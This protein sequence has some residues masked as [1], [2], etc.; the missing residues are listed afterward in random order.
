METSSPK[1]G[2]DIHAIQA[3]ALRLDLGEPEVLV[4]RANPNSDGVSWEL[5]VVELGQDEK[6]WE[7]AERVVATTIGL[8]S[9]KLKHLDKPL[10]GFDRNRQPIEFCLIAIDAD[11]NVVD[12]ALEPS[13]G[14]TWLHLGEALPG[15]AV[16]SKIS[17]PDSEGARP[18]EPRPLRAP[19]KQL[20]L[21]VVCFWNWVKRARLV[22]ELRVF[23]TSSYRTVLRGNTP[24]WVRQ[25]ME[26]AFKNA[27]DAA[28]HMRVNEGWRCLHE[29]RRLELFALTEEELAVQASI[30][31]AE[32]HKQNEFENWRKN[33]VMT[34]TDAEAVKNR[35]ADA[36][37]QALYLS[38]CI[39]DE[40]FEDDYYRLSLVSA[41]TM[42]MS[43]ALALMLGLILSQ[44]DDLAP[45]LGIT[46]LISMPMIALLGA[47]GGGFSA[48]VSFTRI[49]ADKR[50]PGRI[51]EAL[52]FVARPVIGAISAIIVIGAY[53]TGVVQITGATSETGWLILLLAF[54][55]GFSERLVMAAMERI[56]AKSSTA[57]SDKPG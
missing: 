33:A 22:G 13:Q 32:I 12:A 11:E 53:Q 19:P 5:P 56:N 1:N 30:L 34:L 44:W 40:Q 42:W 17:T 39:R 18:A 54:G 7:A 51:R 35:S 20:N 6:P 28:M 14:W 37:R 24:A 29:A 15:L 27:W 45:R 23:E 4:V 43:L 46:S 49:A 50:I 38:A 41:A 25:A 47:L 10:S 36:T 21:S 2:Q 57:A 26:Q 3:I 31:P 8:S 52:G 16:A 9:K 48:L 55:A